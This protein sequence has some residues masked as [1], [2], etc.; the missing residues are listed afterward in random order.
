MF[1]RLVIRVLLL[2]LA[3]AIPALARAAEEKAVKLDKPG[4]VLRV[5]AFDS[6]VADLRYLLEK[7]G[8]AETAKQLDGIIK[9]KVGEKGLEGI[10]TKKPF[11]AYGWIGASGID[12][13]LVVLL[14]V[15]DEKAFLSLL[16]DQLDAKADKGQD[17][18]YTINHDKV[19]FPIFLRFSNGYAY[20]TVRDKELL[21][22]DKLLAPGVV[23]P[24]DRVGT[25]SLTLDIDQVPDKLKELALGKVDL[26]LANAKDK[27][28]PNESEA[29]KKVR[30]AAL[31]QVGAAVKSVLNNGGE[32]TLRLDVDRK[33]AELT[34]SLNVAG[35][36]GSPLAKTIK[37]LGEAQSITA[38]LLTP[39]SVLGGVL[40]LTVPPKI[41]DQ[42]RPL[43]DAFEKKAVAQE[44]DQASREALTSLLDALKPTL[45]DRKVDVAADLRGPGEA[46]RYTGIFAI[47][48]KDGAG[49]EKTI[50]KVVGQMPAA[51]RKTIAF[52]VEKVDQVAIHRISL[53]KN[54][55]NLEM[56]G[57]NQLYVAIREDAVLASLGE[58]GLAAL[59]DALAAAPAK[60]K[61][62]QFQLAMKGLAPFLAKQ[63]KSAPEIAKEVFAK[64]QDDDKVRVTVEGGNTLK[65]RLNMRAQLVAFFTKL[66]QAQKQGE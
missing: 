14:P 34:V 12:S 1:R 30:A 65:V 56:F 59:K 18:L 6:L 25:L 32:T 24:A 22:K 26:E 42:L 19:P 46:G 2:G 39:K 40:N 57:D 58:K 54:D 8:Q 49:I 41:Y 64:N 31:D 15:A 23:L 52:D 63:N 43:F 51:Q 53:D 45:E 55:K 37:D 38:G 7:A 20:A 36:A 9:S 35:K 5:S 61:V 28:A 21:A 4:V 60:G 10:D 16:A 62:A 66:A 50:R 29:E 27:E 48:V 3:L 44:K 33:A 47:K 13:Q 11:G 17:D